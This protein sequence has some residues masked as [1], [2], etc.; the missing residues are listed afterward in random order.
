MSVIPLM[1]MCVGVHAQTFRPLSEKEC[2]EIAVPAYKILDSVN[3][4]IET[5][6]GWR[7]NDT[8]N[9]VWFRDSYFE[10][11]QAVAGF[12]GGR[13]QIFDSLSDLGEIAKVDLARNGYGDFLTLENTPRGGSGVSIE[14]ALIYRLSENKL[15]P[16]FQGW[17][18][19]ETIMPGTG[20]CHSRRL[21][22]FS[23]DAAKSSLT[24]EDDETWLDCNTLDTLRVSVSKRRLRYSATLHRFVD[25]LFVA[26]RP[27]DSPGF[28]RGIRAG[29][30]LGLAFDAE[31]VSGRALPVSVFVGGKSAT[32]DYWELTAIL[33]E[34]FKPVKF[35]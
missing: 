31:G 35:P 8:A 19:E 25:R 32:T 1:L 15:R 34:S 23:F 27:L 28:P 7:L 9:V 26:T 29:D 17:M 14:M 20:D 5:C 3:V 6:G 4:K 12:R 18:K 33:A 11:F 16:V 2:N 21:K 10:S 30:T 24:F 22:D 13:F